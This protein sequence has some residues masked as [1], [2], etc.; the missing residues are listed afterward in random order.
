MSFDL[1]NILQKYLATSQHSAPEQVEAD[2]QQATQHASSESVANGVS[3]AL[4]SDQTPPFAS[5]VGQLFGNGDSQQRTGMVNQLIHSLGPTV[6]ASIAGGALGK[7]FSG[8][9]ENNVTNQVPQLTPD[10]VEQ[11]TPDQ[12]NQIAATAEQHNPSVVDRMGQFYAEH[13]SLVKGIGAAG[14]AIALGHIAQ[15][16]RAS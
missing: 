16:R 13:P 1:Q 10:Q 15:G 2:F 11:L 7:V 14:L 4:R 9:N 12:V 5:M 3:E 8:N 6:L